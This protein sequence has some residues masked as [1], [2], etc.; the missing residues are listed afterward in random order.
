MELEVS[1]QESHS[2]SFRLIATLG[3]AGFFSGL[4][5][6]G[7][8]LIT[9]PI[10]EADKAKALKEAVFHVVPGSHSFQTLVLQN[11]K[12][13]AQ[14]TD[15]SGKQ[16]KSSGE[17]ER[18]FACY[19]ESKTLLGF[20]IPGSEP[21]FQ[22]VIQGIF[23]Y[24]SG[25]KIIIGFEVLQSRETPGLGDKIIKDKNFRANFTALSI[26]PE[27]IPVKPG[28][29]QQENQVETITGATIS[30]KAVVRLLQKSINRWRPAIEG[31]FQWEN[32]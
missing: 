6:V 30:S 17:A 26:I 4:A 31:W 19:D 8:Y 12:L 13:L 20:A 25:K 10:I 18:I 29:K 21:G 9:L 7:V 11:G 16:K 27:L 3:I 24:D 32:Q 2:S 28:A 22:D 14:E 1:Q 23:G 5:L 15:N